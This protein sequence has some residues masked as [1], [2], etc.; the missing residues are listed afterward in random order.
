MPAK[1]EYQ[2]ARHPGLLAPGRVPRP[3][4]LSSPAPPEGSGGQWRG[5]PGPQED[6][7]LCFQIRGVA[8][9]APIISS[10]EVVG[11][12]KRGWGARALQQNLTGGSRAPGCSDQTTAWGPWAL[13]KE[14]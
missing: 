6:P 14:G 3:A 5:H 11:G 1:R 13:R 8:C 2:E 9:S 12:F 4:H 7:S 10:L